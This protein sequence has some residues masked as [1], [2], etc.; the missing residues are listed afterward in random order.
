M[1]ACDTAWEVKLTKRSDWYRH[2]AATNAQTPAE[3]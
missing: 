2:V 3:T 1:M